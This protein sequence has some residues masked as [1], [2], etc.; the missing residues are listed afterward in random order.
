MMTTAPK[1][2]TS[3]EIVELGS[4]ALPL[5]NIDKNSSSNTVYLIQE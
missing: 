1:S 5:D 2:P 3:N 4:V